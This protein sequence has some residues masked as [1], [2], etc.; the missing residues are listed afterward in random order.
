PKG[1]EVFSNSFL[2]K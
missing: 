2:G 1:I